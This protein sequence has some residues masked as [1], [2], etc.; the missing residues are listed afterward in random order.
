MQNY[1]TQWWAI[2]EIYITKN[3]Y[4]TLHHDFFYDS[5]NSQ[6]FT[7]NRL[8]PHEFESDCT[9]HTCSLDCASAVKANYVSGV[10]SNKFSHMDACTYYKSLNEYSKFHW[11][12]C[13]L[14]PNIPRLDVYNF[15]DSKS[16][17]ASTSKILLETLSEPI[18]D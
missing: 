4:S 16:N 1:L 15:Q 7:T 18:L 10:Y 11:I 17:Y 8:Y 9:N 3:E 13:D 5:T 14:P 6:H 12:Q 2:D